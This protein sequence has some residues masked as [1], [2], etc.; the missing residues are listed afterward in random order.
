MCE[1]LAR[2]TAVQV[3]GCVQTERH[4]EPR[5]RRT[6]RRLCWGRVRH[7]R[8]TP[9]RSCILIVAVGRRHAQGGVGLWR[10]VFRTIVEVI[11]RGSAGRA[12]HVVHA[13][14]PI[15]RRADSNIRQGTQRSLVVCRPLGGPR[16]R[17]FP[18]PHVCVRAP[19][20][21]GT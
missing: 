2:A 12:R 8:G 1:P 13:H 17:S 9:F 7:G 14:S 11:M 15:L 10:R 6:V 3:P 18:H 19:I 21:A 5:E 20:C 16:V 4:V